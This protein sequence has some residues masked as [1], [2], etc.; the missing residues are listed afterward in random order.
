MRVCDF[1]PPAFAAR[2]LCPRR[3]SRPGMGW[4]W[5]RVLCGIAALNVYGFGT[6]GSRED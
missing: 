5:G 4:E 6:E 2:M 3:P 1:R